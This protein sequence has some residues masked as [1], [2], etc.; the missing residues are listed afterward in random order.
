MTDKETQKLI[1][2]TVAETVRQLKAEGLLEDATPR[3]KTEELLRQYPTMDQGD[4]HRALIDVFL[5]E[6]ES[7]PY[8][9]AIRLY[10]FAGHK[11]TATATIMCST[12]RT[13]RRNRLRLVDM[14]ADK[15]A[16]ANAIKK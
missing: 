9:D 8:L 3:R 1:E 16:A 4:K 14:L 2:A 11:S 5:A 7:D 12:E 6:N 10:Y 13:C 15:L